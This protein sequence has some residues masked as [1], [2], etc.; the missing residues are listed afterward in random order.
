MRTKHVELIT[1]D[2]KENDLFHGGVGVTVE[3]LTERL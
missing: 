2:V 1:T 3:G